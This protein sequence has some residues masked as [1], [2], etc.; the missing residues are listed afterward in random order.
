MTSGIIVGDAR[1][2]LRSLT[3]GSIRCCVTSP[4]YWG[5]RDYK[6][7]NQIGLEESP[8]AYTAELVKVF[9]E[10]RRV[11]ADD[12]TLWLNLGDSYARGRVN[13]DDNRSAGESRHRTA[14]GL[15]QK[16]LVGIPW[17]V[18]F[19]LQADGWYLRAEI[20]WSKLNPMP[21]SV[22][23]RPTRSHEQIFLFAKSPRYY[24]NADAVKEPASGGP[25]GNYE[26]KLAD[27]ED[28]RLDTHLGRS[29]P[30]P[31]NRFR[32]RRSVWT[33]SSEPYPGAHFAVMPRAIV[34]PC[35]LAGSEPH[36]TVLDPFTG[37]ATVGAVAL[38]EGRLFVGCEINPEY[39]DLGANRLAEEASQALLFTPAG[40]PL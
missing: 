25:S 18:A 34:R 4:P 21:E 31:G 26:R 15:Q 2:D 30:W 22:R 11:L 35:I 24:Y 14:R 32:N 23:D 28:Q 1:T 6:V 38:Q 7:K 37:T 36:D 9:R 10:V 33:T 5:L 13:R 20:V 19:A 39:A 29:I 27:G 12:G 40:E 16:N 8:E 17:R 3:A